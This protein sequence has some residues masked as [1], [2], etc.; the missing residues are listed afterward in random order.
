MGDFLFQL[1]LKRIKKRGERYKK[2][3]KVRD[4]YGEYW[5]DKSTKKVSNVMLI[6]IVV[7]IV[8]YVIADFVLQYKMGIEISPTITTCWFVFW[9]TEIVA[10]TGIKVSKVCKGTDS[11]NE[12][13][14]STAIQNSDENTVG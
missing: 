6:V 5:P 12:Y 7:A 1:K 3:K 9:G 4:A 11:C 8:G 10:L 14:S 2:E 13:G